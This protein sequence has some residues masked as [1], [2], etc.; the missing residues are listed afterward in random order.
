[1]PKTPTELIQE[2]AE[3]PRAVTGQAGSLTNHSLTETIAAARE[4]DRRAR[5]KNGNPFAALQ[6][7]HVSPGG[8]V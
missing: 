6:R 1:M 7:C 5:S 2:A 4:L 3:S 8:A